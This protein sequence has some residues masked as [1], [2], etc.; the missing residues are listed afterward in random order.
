MVKYK[1][2]SVNNLVFI[3][4]KREENSPLFSL[5]KIFCRLKRV[6]KSPS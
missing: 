4:K 6:S 2:T 1:H 5:D 3:S